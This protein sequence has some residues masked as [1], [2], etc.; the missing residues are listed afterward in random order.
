M[1]RDRSAAAIYVNVARE[2]RQLSDQR[3][4]RRRG[5]VSDFETG[6]PRW[7]YRQARWLPTLE[8]THRE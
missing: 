5:L 4:G 7:R 8:A 6:L 3:M 2:A 1:L